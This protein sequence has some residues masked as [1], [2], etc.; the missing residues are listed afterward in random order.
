LY[1]DLIEISQKMPFV[2]SEMSTLIIVLLSSFVLIIKTG[3][4]FPFQSTM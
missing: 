1:D 2:S 4:A 3:Y